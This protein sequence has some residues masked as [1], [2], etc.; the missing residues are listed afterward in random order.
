MSSGCSKALVCKPDDL[1]I[2]FYGLPALA[3]L[4]P[5]PLLL[6]LVSV[7]YVLDIVVVMLRGVS[8]ML[9]SFRQYCFVLGGGSS[10]GGLSGPVRVGWML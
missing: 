10:P 5:F 9:P 8:G 3:Y 7:Y 4:S 1:S 6:C 2:C